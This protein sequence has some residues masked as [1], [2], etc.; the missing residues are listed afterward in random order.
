LIV[1]VARQQLFT[2]NTLTAVLPMMTHPGWYAAWRLLRLWGIVLLGN[3]AGVGLFAFAM[4][5]MPVLDATT[6]AVLVDMGTEVLRNT[7][8]EMFTRGIV[9]GWLLGTMVWMLP[10]LP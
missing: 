5:R 6:H 4:V 7:T 3:L 2:E 10:A 1:V 8:P 9:A